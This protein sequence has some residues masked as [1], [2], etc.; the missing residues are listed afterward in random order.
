MRKVIIK[1]KNG[2]WTYNSRPLNK[3]TFPEAQ[4]VSTFI[5]NSAFNTESMYK[6]DE[7]DNEHLIHAEDYNYNFVKP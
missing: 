5:K 4:V 3:C 6:P 7:V 2:Y 1:V